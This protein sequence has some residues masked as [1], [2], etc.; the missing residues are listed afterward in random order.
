MFNRPYAWIGVSV[1]AEGPALTYA[2]EEAGRVERVPLTAGRVWL[3]AA[4]DF[5]REEARFS[6]ST[7][8][9]IF[10]PIG[11]P[12]RLVFQLMTFQGVRY[13]LFAFGSGGGFADFDAIDVR[14]PDPR[15][16]TI[17]IPYGRAIELA[18]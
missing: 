13:S 1:D 17:P 6:Y 2:T 5:L 15:G 10:Q 18:A 16:L 12:F 4:C 3:R 8:G 14:E 7:D 9:R 11:D